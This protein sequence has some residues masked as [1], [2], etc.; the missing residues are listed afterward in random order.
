MAVVA[1]VV[2]CMSV[3]IVSMIVTMIVMSVLLMSTMTVAGIHMWDSVE[4][5]VT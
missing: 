3:V 2:S 4:K 1:V 5:D